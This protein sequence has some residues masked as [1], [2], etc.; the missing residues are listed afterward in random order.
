MLLLLFIL[1]AGG[2]KVPLEG[3]LH[4]FLRETHSSPGPRRSFLKPGSI[5]FMFLQTIAFSVQLN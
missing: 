5:S 2:S 1:E 4:L 3:T